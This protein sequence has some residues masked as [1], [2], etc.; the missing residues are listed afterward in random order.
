MQIPT[1]QTGPGV[2]D[3]CADEHLCCIETHRHAPRDVTP[4]ADFI[5]VGL[6]NNQRCVLAIEPESHEDFAGLL[7]NRG[8]DVPCLLKSETLI[9][10]EALDF[11]P[12][13]D[14]IDPDRMTANLAA[15]VRRARQEGFDGLRAIGV[16]PYGSLNQEQ[17][18]KFVEYEAQIGALLIGAGLRALCIYHENQ[19]PPAQLSQILE[20]HPKVQFRNQTYDNPYYEPPDEYYASDP[21]RM[22]LERML[23]TLSSL[24]RQRQALIESEHRYRAL[25]EASPCGILLVQDG[26]YVYCNPA[27]AR[28]LGLESP[29][30]AVGADAMETIDAP[31]RQAVRQ[32]IS[33]IAKG[34]PNPP[35]EIDLRRPDGT[36]LP[37]ESISV[38]IEYNAAPAA[39]VIG[40]DISRRR[41]R[42]QQQE[43]IQKQEIQLQQ[44]R[45]LGELAG[46]IAHDFNNLLL[47]VTG[48]IECIAYHVPQ[49]PEVQS[50]MEEIRKSTQRAETLC[51]RLLAY[52]GRGQFV[53]APGDLNALLEDLAEELHQ[54]AKDMK[55]SIHTEPNLPDARIDA[56]QIRDAL[57]QLVNNAV[58]ASTPGATIQIQTTTR[59]CQDPD[60]PIGLIG[61]QLAPGRYACLEVRD[62]GCGMDAETL[63]HI[64]EPFY[65]T[66]FTG[67]GLGMP[68]VMGILR[69]H[70]G[71]MEVESQ[72]G[73]GT[74]VRLYL[75][76]DQQPRARTK[77]AHADVESPKARP[78]DAPRRILLADDEPS[79]VKLLTR[80]LTRAGYEVVASRDGQEALECF[81]R[82]DG[83]FAAVL[84]DVTMPRMGGIEALE[85]LR[86]RDAG[87]P[88]ILSSGYTR[89]EITAH[90]EPDAFARFLHKPY[91]MQQLLSCLEELAG[92]D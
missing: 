65:T 15:Q 61:E 33:N 8:F 46:G 76:V 48:N 7:S 17:A 21:C 45:S 55:L 23:D 5:Q 50:S 58:E 56:Q 43:Q 92:R 41:R 29:E 1:I 52:A 22:R 32:R 54:N 3:P 67:R 78:S 47:A 37:V 10:Q 26:K 44:Y 38:P 66:K 71:L 63:G 79:V 69:G 81:A 34:Q 9:L 80:M 12:P 73:Q 11:Y 70:G 91:Q 40:R 4:L 82:H 64:C 86:R 28:M 18:Q 27:G 84:L 60:L 31:Y 89:E 90:L 2:Q 24:G 77:K 19:M 39:I 62:E 36:L 25:V 14:R 68:S 72:P 42:E 30:N 6:E 51:R 20:L 59:N 75:P 85:E 35:M 49:E 16:I 74:T 53:P 88:V 57:V 83:Q 13:Q 87:I